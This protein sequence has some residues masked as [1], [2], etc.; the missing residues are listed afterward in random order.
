MKKTVFVF[1][2]LSLFANLAQLKK[3]NTLSP[4]AIHIFADG[5]AFQLISG[6]IALHTIPRAYW[7]DRMKKAR[8]RD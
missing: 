6:E 4:S 1:L 3:S 7:R 5:K 2:I 8:A